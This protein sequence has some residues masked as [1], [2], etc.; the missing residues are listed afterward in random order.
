VVE[1]AGDAFPWLTKEVS[2]NTD[3]KGIASFDDTAIEYSLPPI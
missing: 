1:Q 3:G 2:H